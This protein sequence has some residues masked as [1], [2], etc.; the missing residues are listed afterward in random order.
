MCR[1][2]RKKQLSE[3]ESRLTKGA[4]LD[5]NA[6]YNFVTVADCGGIGAAARATGLSKATLSRRLSALEEKL[7][8][9][10]FD[11]K[12]SAF[13]LTAAGQAFRDRC[14][15]LIGEAARIEDF[16][17]SNAARAGVADTPE[18]AEPVVDAALVQSD[19]TNGDDGSLR[20]QDFAQ[21]HILQNIRNQSLKSGD[22]LP[23]ERSLAAELNMSRQSVREAIRSLEMTGVLELQ[24][25]PQGGS[26]IREPGPDG[27]ANSIRNMLTLGNLP[28]ADLLQLRASIFAQAAELA[29]LAHD[30]SHIEA[31]EE[32]LN[33]LRIAN[34]MNEPKDTIALSTGFYRIAGH[35]SGN[36]LLAILVDAIANVIEELLSSMKGWP[37]VAE[38]E[39]ARQEALEAIRA[40]DSK[41]AEAI[42]RDHCTETNPVLLKARLS[43]TNE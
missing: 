8:M 18:R 7:G 1:T 27:I 32:N 33:Q 12:S 5:L 6:I 4:M 26:F 41:A 28:L 39:V 2:R 23:S 31:L 29:A 40:G 43:N 42:I 22:K 34:R 15:G 3:P 10:L 25:G 30:R 9:E 35:A 38:G 19:M 14:D 21:H 16:L 36:R 17:R 11:R 20:R 24:R 37:F 13:R